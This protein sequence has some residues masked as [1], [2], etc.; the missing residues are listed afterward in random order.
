M[1]RNTFCEIIAT[2]LII[3]SFSGCNVQRSGFEFRQTDQGIELNENGK[4]VFFYQKVPKSLT[5]EYI[6]TNYIHP[7]YNLKGDVLTEEFPADHPFHRG[8]F[9]T[10]HQIYIDTTSIGD[11]WINKGISQDVVKVLT[12]KKNGQAVINLEVL[13]N[14]DSLPAGEPFMREK[15]SI[16]V[17]PSESDIRKIDFTIELDALIAK[18]EIGGSADAKGYGGLCLRLNIPDSMVFTSVN[19]TV[20][21]Q[22]LQVS[23]SPWMDFSGAFSDDQNKTGIAILCHPGNPLFPSPWILRQK[24][25]MQNAVYPGKE[26]IRLEMNKPLVLRYRLIIHNGDVQAVNLNKLQA[27]YFGL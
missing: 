9:W 22:E 20:T 13:W 15:T 21:P 2:A 26:R 8:V 24:G 18:L 27:E 14:S 16:I 4:P 6:C 11:G 12:E 3:G 25:S 1:N 19:G 17:H 23:A 5:G 10:W 7:L